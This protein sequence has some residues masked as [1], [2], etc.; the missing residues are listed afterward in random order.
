MA[1][2]ISV[3][4]LLLTTLVMLFTMVA[5]GTV[6]ADKKDKQPPKK[7]GGEGCTPG[8][9][10]Q[11]HHF[12]NWTGYTPGQNFDTVFGVNFFNPDKTLLQAVWLGGGGVNALARHAVAALLNST[13]A[14]VDYDLNTAQVIAIVQ[15][16]GASGDYEGAKNILAAFN[17]QGCDLARAEAA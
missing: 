10:R 4:T 17:E 3:F 13:S 1:R 9:W 8:Y 16:A 2:R 12:G 11:E 14:N 7:E 15:A 5:A 6:S